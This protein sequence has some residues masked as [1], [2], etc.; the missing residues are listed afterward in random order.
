M[1]TFSS[2]V[3]EDAPAALLSPAAV[4]LPSAFVSAAVLLRCL[5][6][7]Y[8]QNHMLSWRHIM[9]ATM[10]I[11]TAFLHFLICITLLDIRISFLSPLS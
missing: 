10:H 7:P 2:R 8:Y 3:Q 1:V 4:S 9:T 6:F 5:R 11:A